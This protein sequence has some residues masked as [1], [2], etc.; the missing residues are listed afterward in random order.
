M[1]KTYVCDNCGDE[2]QATWSD[3][4]A[5]AEFERNFPSAAKAGLPRSEICDDCYKKFM[6]WWKGDST[7]SQ[8]AQ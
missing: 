4:E 3:E 1:G 5:S 2:C 6:G 8:E 7:V